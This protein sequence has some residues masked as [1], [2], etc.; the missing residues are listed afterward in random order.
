MATRPN[1]LARTPFF[2]QL[3]WR[4]PE[5][6]AARVFVEKFMIAEV[7]IHSVPEGEPPAVS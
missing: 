7:W 5:I 2:T 3:S 4:S 6:L 1:V